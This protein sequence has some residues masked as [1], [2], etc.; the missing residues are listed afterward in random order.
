MKYLKT[1]SDQETRKKIMDTMNGHFRFGE[2]DISVLCGK[3][4]E[5]LLGGQMLSNLMCYECF[6]NQVTVWI[7]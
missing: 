5:L 7:S 3:N 6:S 2:D 4:Q 1:E